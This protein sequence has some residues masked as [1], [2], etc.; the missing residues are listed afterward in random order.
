VKINIP[1][2][3]NWESLRDKRGTKLESHYIRLLRELGKQRGILGQIFAKSQNKIQDPAKLKRLIN[4]IDEETWV[5]M[6]SD[7]KGDIYEGLHQKYAE[8]TKSG[9]GQYFNPRPLI[10]AMVK[11]IDPEPNK[12]IADPACGSGGFF[13]STLK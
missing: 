13:Q 11:C 2:D 12:T 10:R 3:Y 7:V 8:D 4:M 9:A 5:M 6:S 1:D